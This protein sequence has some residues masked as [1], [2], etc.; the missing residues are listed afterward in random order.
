M[1]AGL[2]SW[3]ATH[4][5]LTLGVCHGETFRVSNNKIRS[6]GQN[7][8]SQPPVREPGQEPPVGVPH[9]PPPVES[10]PDEEAPPQIDPPGPDQPPGPWKIN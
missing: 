5:S 9:S 7:D 2:E 3:A 4:R 1:A 8:P 10:P 6:L